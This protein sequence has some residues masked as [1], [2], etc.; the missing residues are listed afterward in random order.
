M[1]HP[2][3]RNGSPLYTRQS[4]NGDAESTSPGG[5][6]SPVHPHSSSSYRG[7][8]S[9]NGF[10]SIKRSQ[11]VAA[12]AAAQ[13]LAQVMASHNDATTDNDD[14]DDDSDL[15]SPPP[16]S[17]S[18]RP[19]SNNLNNQNRNR[20][21]LVAKPNGS[22]RS[23]S[24][25]LG[26]NSVE[27]AQSARSTSAGRSSATVR[28]T[29]LIPPRANASPNRTSSRTQVSVPML[30]P[31]VNPTRGNASPSRTSLRNQVSYPPMQSRANASPSRTSLRTQ[32]SLPLMEPSLSPPRARA[33]PG[34]TS[35]RS[36]DRIPPTEPPTSKQRDKRL[37]S[38]VGQ[39]LNG[40]GNR[41]EAS[42]LH[43]EL[44][45]LQE[46][47]DNMLDKLRLAEERCKEV[48]ARTK[49]LEKQVASLGEGASMEA[50]L[51]SRKEAALRQREAAY[52]A[53]KQTK[54]ER[55]EEISVLRIEAANAKEV[56]VAAAAQVREAESDMKA[57][58][59]MTQRMILTQEEMEE[60][61][62][63]RCWLARYWGLAVWHG[64]CADIAAAKHEHWSSLAPLPFEV[65]IS[66]GQ[67]AKDESPGVVDLD[68]MNLTRGFSDLTG[69]GNIE[70]I[71]SVEMGLR[72]L[73]SLKVE[74]A[75]V[76]ALTQHRRP[77][78][79][80]QSLSEL[81]PDESEDV[82]F[83]QA[84]LT[85]FWRRAKAHGVKEKIA[86]KRLTFLIDRSQHAPTSHDAVKVEKCI[87]ELRKLG[88]ERKLWE[89]SRKDLENF[90]TSL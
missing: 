82:L 23:Q 87:M 20:V 3:R 2:R 59:S 86:E 66:A 47:N 41:H 48:E 6:M 17:F 85:Y 56:A 64:I 36:R 13:R 8:Y 18:N 4:R 77:N 58:R 5:G 40:I 80:R 10:S 89:A 14:D 76:L 90:E 63:K 9:A 60:V 78:L 72:E 25:A 74:E 62:L 7:G 46:E 15:Y 50:K 65:V 33:S 84:W 27:Q 21:P 32:V 39:S 69:E 45:M 31:S 53:G 1:D 12:K 61:V 24:P 88:I 52:K 28:S 71:L 30:E 73:V 11:N 44:D 42:A 54:D 57:L 55:D 37:S 38:D 16:I 43:D 22:T 19:N 49:E 70:S 26:R 29:P 67:K 34:R 83:K 79:V 75:V 51:L 81:S 68:R 35:M